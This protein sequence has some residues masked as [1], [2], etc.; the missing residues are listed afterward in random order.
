V[1]AQKS[2]STIQVRSTSEIVRAPEVWLPVFFEEI[3]GRIRS[4]AK[5]RAAQSTLELTR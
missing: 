3:P 2:Q 5:L 1:Q 4:G